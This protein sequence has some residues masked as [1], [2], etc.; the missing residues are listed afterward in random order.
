VVSGLC[1]IQEMVPIAGDNDH[2]VLR[3]IIHYILI[4]APL[5]QKF[6]SSFYVMPLTFQN[7]NGVNRHIV[8]Q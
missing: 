5:A 7:A 3:R 6:N 4:R 2:P 8:I 1:K